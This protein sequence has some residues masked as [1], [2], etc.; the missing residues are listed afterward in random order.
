[1]ATAQYGHTARLVETPP[2]SASPASCSRLLRWVIRHSTSLPN[3]LH[4]ASEMVVLATFA[5]LFQSLISV[6][7]WL[8]VDPVCTVLQCASDEPLSG[9]IAPARQRLIRGALQDGT[10]WVYSM[11]TSF[12]VYH[13][14]VY[15]YCMLH[16]SVPIDFFLNCQV[17]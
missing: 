2:S 17:I 13:C 9:S 3:S 1:M 12:T 14:I 6:R 11:L 15:D 4:L 16:Y 10:H 8:M 5:D 7:R